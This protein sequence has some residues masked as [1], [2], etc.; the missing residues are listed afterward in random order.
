MSR[1]LFSA[2]V[3]RLATLACALALG[4]P[5]RAGLPAPEAHLLEGARH[6]REGRFGA[7]LIE[8]RVADRLGAP[9]PA[10]WYASAALVKLGRHEEAVAGFAEAAAAH[11]AGRDGLLDFYRAVAL[12]ESRLYLQA[13]GVLA[14]IAAVGPRVAEQIAELRARIAKIF[15]APP[16]RATIDWYH[17]RARAAREAA[18]PALA[19]AFAAEALA[20]AARR[21]DGYRAEEAREV[22][23]SVAHGSEASR[24]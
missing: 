9:G 20:L 10:R 22:M 24:P 16:E 6:F 7:A 17:A 14:G 11:P 18:R 4:G 13:D 23:G 15:A 21:A 3:L 8:F 1:F 19:G 5:A 12:H 2:G